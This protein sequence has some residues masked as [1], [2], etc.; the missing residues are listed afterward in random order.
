[1]SDARYYAHPSAVVDPGAEIGEGTAIWHFVHVTGGARVGQEC[2]FGHGCFVGDVRIGDRV[3]AQNHVSIYAGVEIEDDVFLGPSCVFTNVLNPRAVTRGARPFLPTH[4]RR[5]ATIGAN[6]TAICGV[7]IGAYAFVGAGA[8]VRRDVGTHE[9]VVGTP[10]RRI[11]WICGC[12]ERLDA[13]PAE[14][15]AC[16]ACPT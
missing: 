8:V 15:F 14:P 3:R 2:S 7:E 12:G 13:P 4:V 10:A 6:A 11:G 5:G 9:V 1:M 16:G